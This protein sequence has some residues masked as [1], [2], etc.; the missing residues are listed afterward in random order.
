MAKTDPDGRE[1]GVA[2]GG[3]DD[4]CR[5]FAKADRHFGAVDKLDVDLGRVANAQ[6]AYR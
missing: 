3:S 2:D 5:R 1:D 6:V 4:S